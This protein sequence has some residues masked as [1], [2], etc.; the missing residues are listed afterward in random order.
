MS[1]VLGGQIRS[2]RETLGLNQKQF[3]ELLGVKA[4]GNVRMWENG[5]TKPTGKRWTKLQALFEEHLS[6]GPRQQELPVRDRKPQP[7]RRKQSGF[8]TS[9]LKIIFRMVEAFENLS[10][11]GQ[12]KFKKLIN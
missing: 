7:R 5:E 11:D 2:L 8:S 9:E 3:A 1:T 12:T 10:H 4:G 6:D